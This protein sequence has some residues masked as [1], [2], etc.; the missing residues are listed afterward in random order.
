MK[1]NVAGGWRLN[2]TTGKPHREGSFIKNVYV[3]ALEVYKSYRAKPDL[4]H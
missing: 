2:A 3:K 1:K 4:P